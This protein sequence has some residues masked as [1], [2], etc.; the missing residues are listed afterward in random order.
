[1]GYTFKKI[2]WRWKSNTIYPNNINVKCYKNAYIHS[3]RIPKLKLKTS[4]F[5][6][7]LKAEE[8]KHSVNDLFTEKIMYEKNIIKSK[9]YTLINKKKYYQVKNVDTWK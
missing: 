9:Y 5:N 1:M 7:T 8:E 6:H 3:A 4:N 2:I